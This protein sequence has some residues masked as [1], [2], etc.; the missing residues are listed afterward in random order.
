MEL[1]SPGSQ[2]DTADDC[3]FFLFCTPVMRQ[4]LLAEVLE[5]IMFQTVKST[6]I[7]S[8]SPKFHFQKQCKHLA[9]KNQII[10]K[11]L[12]HIMYCRN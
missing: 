2:W 9:A 1:S 8:Q 4:Q 7:L 11:I 12:L 5:E 6:K 10:L 3:D